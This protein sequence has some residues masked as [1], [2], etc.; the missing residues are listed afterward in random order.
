MGQN[1]NKFYIKNHIFWIILTKFEES[2]LNYECNLKGLLNHA[3]PL[4]QYYLRSYL[5]LE[6]FLCFQKRFVF[7]FFLAYQMI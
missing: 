7:F 3:S 5:L 6:K 1:N 2:R 4:I